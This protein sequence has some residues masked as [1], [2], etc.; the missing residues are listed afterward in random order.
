[1][2]GEQLDFFRL[3]EL[4]GD[5]FALSGLEAVILH[6]HLDGNTAE[7]AALLLDRELERVTNVGAD[8]AAGARQGR[9][10]ADP[11][12]LLGLRRHCKRCEQR[13]PPNNLTRFH[14]MLPNAR[15][16]FGSGS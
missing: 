7:L 13:D 9:D 3:E 11:D 4:V 12:R 1:M 8:V 16:R 5:L 14:L 10:Q 6:Y 15:R 2:P